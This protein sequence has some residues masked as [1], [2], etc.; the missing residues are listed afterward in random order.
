MYGILKPQAQAGC[1]KLIKVIFYWIISIYFYRKKLCSNLDE[2]GIQKIPINF[3]TIYRLVI[4]V[5]LT[6]YYNCICIIWHTVQLEIKLLPKQ[7]DKKFW[8][9]LTSSQR[10]K[11][12]F[13][14]A[15]LPL[16][17]VK[18][19]LSLIIICLAFLMYN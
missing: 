11:K 2:T 1:L 16:D 9:H 14:A 18:N 10:S 19:E 8:T 5:L 3:R 6:K 13:F 17:C 15:N 12:K 4:A 7:N